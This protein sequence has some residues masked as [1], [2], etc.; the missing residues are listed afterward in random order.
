[1]GLNL[2]M[3]TYFVIVR[4]NILPSPEVGLTGRMIPVL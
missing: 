3:P 4:K 1:M 2:S